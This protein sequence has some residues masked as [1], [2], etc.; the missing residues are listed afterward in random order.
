MKRIFKY[1]SQNSLR[2]FIGAMIVVIG[3][4]MII[5]ELCD[6]IKRMIE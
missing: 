2:Q 3:G 6:M 4:S 5:A 1:L